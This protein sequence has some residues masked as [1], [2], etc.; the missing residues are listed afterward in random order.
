MAEVWAGIG[1]TAESIYL[2]GDWLI[3]RGRS[4][5]RCGGEYPNHTKHLGQSNYRVLQ[6]LPEH[7]TFFSCKLAQGKGGITSESAHK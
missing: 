6:N 5:F 2:T 4:S 7:S 1:Y 3:L